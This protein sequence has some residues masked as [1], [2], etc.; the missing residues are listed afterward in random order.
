MAKKLSSRRKFLQFLGISAGS[1]I[2]SASAVAG[3]AEPNEV[4]KLNKE[5][6]KFMHDYNKWMDEYVEVIKVQNIDMDNIEN[7]KRMLRL[8]EQ[9]EIWRPTINEYMKDRNFSIIYHASIEKM[10]SEIRF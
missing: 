6:R 10:K 4:L 9:A 1:T 3:L 2:I 5:Q 7:H 8:T